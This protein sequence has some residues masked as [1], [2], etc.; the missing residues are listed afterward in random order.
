M[1]RF[2]E[3]RCRSER[4]GGLGI[5]HM[6]E[7]GKDRNL[8][9]AERKKRMISGIALEKRFQGGGVSRVR[10]SENGPAAF[11]KYVP[12][13]DVVVGS[14]N[15]IAGRFRDLVSRTKPRIMK[16]WLA[17]HGV[18][19]RI[20]HSRGGKFTEAEICAAFLRLGAASRPIVARPPP[21]IGTPIASVCIAACASALF[22]AHILV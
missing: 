22:I 4:P 3:A 10:F 16:Q 7:R 20:P 5:G 19:D 13:G 17:N 18:W 6:K 12:P 21:A 14:D 2:W 9:V 11:R 15:I 1:L 8:G